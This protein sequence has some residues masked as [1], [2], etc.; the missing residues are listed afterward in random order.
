MAK[1]KENKARVVVIPE[2]MICVQKTGGGSHRFANRIIKTGQKVW[3]YPEAIDSFKDKFNE[4]GADYG[5][6]IV[7]TIVPPKV[8][9]KKE[10]EL[11][12]DKFKIVKAVDA[13]GK[14]IKKGKANMYN[15]IG[16]NGDAL[17]EKPLR[18]GKAEELA[19]ALNA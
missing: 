10:L 4:V 18:Q 8:R 2:G 11:I 17:N 9:S 7:Q 14:V 1:N 13:D 5:A 3:V 15:V 12:P 16:S 6:I 19:E